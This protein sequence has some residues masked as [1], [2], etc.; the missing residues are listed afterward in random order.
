MRAFST[1]TVGVPSTASPTDASNTEVLILKSNHWIPQV[2][3]DGKRVYPG[4]RGRKYPSLSSLTSGGC[5]VFYLHLE[6]SF[7]P[8]TVFCSI[9]SCSPL[10]TVARYLVS[11]T[12]HKF[13]FFFH[14]RSRSSKGSLTLVGLKEK[15]NIG[16]AS[17]TTQFSDR[18][19][20]AAA[21]RC[22]KY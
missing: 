18:K 5:I 10:S 17:P 22:Y 3:D 11:I 21:M 4:T 19:F 7:V 6:N 2:L 13:S 12:Q 16:T 14:L 9:L 8:S 1:C 20:S 15:Q